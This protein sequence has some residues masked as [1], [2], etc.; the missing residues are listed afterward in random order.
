MWVVSSKLTSNDRVDRHFGYLLTLVLSLAVIFII[1][2]PLTAYQLNQQ[3]LDLV[4][5]DSLTPI[6]QP[7]LISLESL[8]SAPLLYGAPL[9]TL[10]A[11]VLLLLLALQVHYES[12]DNTV[13]SESIKLLMFIVLMLSVA[14]FYDGQNVVQ[15][16]RYAQLSHS[17]LWDPKLLAADT[18]L[19]GWLF[20]QGQ[21][22]LWLDTDPIIGVTTVV[23]R[24]TAEVLQTVY[25]SYYFWGNGLGVYLAYLYFYHHVYLTNT[26]SKARKREH[27]R[28]IQMF[29]SAWVGGFLFVFVI[30][31]IAPAVSPRIYMK[32]QYVNEI[33][34]YVLCDALR[35]A[36]T[37]AAS[38]TFSAFPSGHCGLSWLCPLLAHRIGYKL[39]RNITIVAAVLIS[40]ATMVMRYHYFVD[41]LAGFI[42]VGVGAWLGQFHTEAAYKAALTDG[43]SDMRGIEADEEGTEE[44]RD[45]RAPLISIVSSD[46]QVDAIATNGI[47][48]ISGEDHLDEIEIVRRGSYDEEDM[49]TPLKQINGVV[50]LNN[51]PSILPRQNSAAKD[52]IE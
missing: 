9:C 20:P 19:L 38:N 21:V 26:K 14:V 16:Y 13:Y 50:K 23:G 49:T 31:L 41:F 27:W 36:V 24:I 33:H 3:Q 37:T 35:S 47:R 2:K 17:M 40:I 45:D 32:D 30:N 34:G 11:L 46:A 7:P 10:W 18:A 15:R 51:A 52:R 5:N 25:V 6:K 29:A 39:F 43:G 8:L 44:D 48:S 42:V 4:N 1:L 12:K 22:A 28:R